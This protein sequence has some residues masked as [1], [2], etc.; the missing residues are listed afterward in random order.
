LPAAFLATLL[1]GYLPYIGVGRKLLGFLGGYAGEEGFDQTGAGF[2][3]WDLV[4]AALPLAGV[5]AAFYVGAAAALL[6]A[7][8]V[9]V[10]FRD[11][12]ADHGIAGAA[13]LATT[14]MVLLTPHYPWYFA[15]LVAFACLV[16]WVSVLWLTAASFLLYLAPVGSHIVNDRHRLMV[17]S[18]LY[19]PF[20]ALVVLDFVRR[21]DR[22]LEGVDR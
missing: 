19:A 20:A 16:P 17:E 9:F 18:A 5:S 22:L 14:F 15:W 12:S 2:Y 8:A 10:V 21:R 3:W 13:L 1:L 7:L 11:R 6:A 4:T